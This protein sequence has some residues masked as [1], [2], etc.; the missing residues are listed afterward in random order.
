MQKNISKKVLEIVKF[1]ES[2][3]STIAIGESC[4]CGALCYEFGKISGVSGVL[5]GGVVCYS[6]DIKHK[7]LG[8]DIEI[9]NNFS[10]YSDEVVFEIIKGVIRV[11]GS[12]YA[13]AVSGLA[14]PSGY[15]GKN[16]NGEI[17]EK[18]AGLVYFCVGSKDHCILEHMH[19]CG[20]RVEVQ[21]KAVEYALDLFVKF[22]FKNIDK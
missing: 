21:S 19:F 20:N 16:S 11:F 4:S 6:D 17:I 1:L 22:L 15:M 18:Q 9:I 5:L 8:V 14:G 13:I 10:V 7:I 2:S 3:N 12:D